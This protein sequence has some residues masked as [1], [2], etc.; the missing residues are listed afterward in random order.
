VYLQKRMNAR[1][2]ALAIVVAAS[3]MAVATVASGAMPAGATSV[4]QATTLHLAFGG[5]MQ[6]PDPDIFYEIEGNAV[7]TSLYEGLVKYANNSTKIVPAL[8]SSW[9]VSPDALTYTF[10]IRPGVKFHDG[11]PVNAAAAQFSFQRRKGVNSAPA[12]MVADVT[13]T[14]TPTPLT[15]VVHLDRPV[16][17]FM[18]YLAAPYSPKLVSPTLVKAHEVGTAPGD[19]AQKYLTTHDAGTGPYTISNFVPGSHYDLAASPRYWGTKPYYSKVNIAIIPDSSTQQVELGNGQLSMILHGLPINAVKSFK[20]NPKFEVKSFPS[21]LKSMLYVNPTL[22]VFKSAAV[23]TALRS[24]IDK[25]GI[26]KSVFGNT[27][28]TVSTQSY[29]VSEFPAGM[30]TDNPTY[31]PSKLQAALKTASGS[32][33]IDLAYSTDDG[34][35]QRVAEFVQTELQA[36]GLSVTLRGVPISQVFNYATTAASKLPNLLIWTVNPDDAHPDSWIRI[37]SNTQG[38]LNE[39][40]A[41]VPAA[42]KLMDA[43]LH[44]TNPKVIQADYAKAGV[45]IANS[46]EQIPIADVRDTVVAAAGISGFYHQPPTIDTVVLGDLHPAGK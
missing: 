2:K 20:S 29:P 22:G 26:V 32:K 24:A 7:V 23:R 38:A 14:T 33:T 10:K 15:F 44:S 40:H 1:T 4:A 3:S 21:E 8:A 39:L 5:D 12:Y 18:D 41:S 31:D 19:W 42:D 16:S 30:A 27:L 28:A 36:E 13:S 11:T 6:V 34:N 25:K 45:L 9:T 43:G 17:A 46:G 35:N 37:F